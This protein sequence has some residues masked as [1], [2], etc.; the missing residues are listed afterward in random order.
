L[1][2]AM[3]SDW[4]N[5]EKLSLLLAHRNRCTEHADLEWV[6]ANSG[7][8]KCDSNAFDQ[9]QDHQ[10]DDTGIAG[11]YRLDAGGLSFFEVGQFQVSSMFQTQM[12]FI[13]I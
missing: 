7:I 10:T 6:A 3:I 1:V 2:S 5:L 11:I 8:L 9:S 13:R 12:R 4:L